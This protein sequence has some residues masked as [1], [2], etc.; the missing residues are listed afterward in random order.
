LEHA[1]KIAVIAVVVIPHSVKIKKSKP[2]YATAAIANFAE[3]NLHGIAGEKKG[4]AA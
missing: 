1:E 3:Q 2:R 4:G